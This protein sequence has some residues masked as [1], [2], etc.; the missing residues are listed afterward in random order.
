MCFLSK[1]YLFVTKVITNVLNEKFI[2]KGVT[3][4]QEGWTN[5]Y[6]EF[7]DK[8]NKN[9]EAEQKLPNIKEK[10]IVKVIKSSVA[11]KK[12]S[13]PPNYTEATLLS[14]MENAGRFVENEDIKE[15]MK[16]S[17]LGTPATRA[18][19]IERLIS[20]GYIERKAKSIVPTEKGKKLIAVIPFQLVSPETT[21]KWEKG[22]SSIAKGNMSQDKFMTSIKKYVNFLVDDAYKSEST[23]V[24][25]DEQRYKAAKNK[26]LGKCPL[27][28]KG[29]ILE[30]TKGFYCSYWKE[31]C[32][33][34]IWKN[35]LENNGIKID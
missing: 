33:F 30:N 16:E 15:Q 19:I 35:S 2:S 21:G 1:I 13:P 27:C 31:G 12:T 22:L 10:D 8:K 18:A 7:E 34:T 11:K 14:A 23:V 25:E 9:K 3:I 5:L 20:V 6:K 29:S 17:G 24:F 32:K 26:S 4:T 28:Q